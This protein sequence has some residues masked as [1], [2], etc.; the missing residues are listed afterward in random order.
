M[1][2]VLTNG[3]FDILVDVIPSMIVM[4]STAAKKVKK[5]NK[6]RKAEF[7]RARQYDESDI[8]EN[9]QKEIKRMSR[10]SSIMEVAF[11]SV[12]IKSNDLVKYT[13]Y[14]T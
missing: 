8:S 2:T 5:N 7:K 6:V 9:L 12:A 1:T 11:T 10:N 14:R 3:L 13:M 4:V